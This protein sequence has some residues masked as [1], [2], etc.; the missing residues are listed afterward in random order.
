MKHTTFEDLYYGNVNP[1][2]IVYDILDYKIIQ[3]KTK[4][5]IKFKNVDIHRFSMIFYRKLKE[6]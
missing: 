3:V 5:Y 2:N 6:E 1:I 4:L